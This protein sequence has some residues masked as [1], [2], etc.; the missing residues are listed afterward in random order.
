V[1]SCRGRNRSWGK[2][3]WNDVA[4]SGLTHASGTVRS[5][6]GALAK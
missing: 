4:W 2:S 5:E 3:F 6:C 1:Q